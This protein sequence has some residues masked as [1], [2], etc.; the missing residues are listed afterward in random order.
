[1]RRRASLLPSLSFALIIA[2]CSS[3]TTASPSAPPAAP[4]AAPAASAPAASA[5]AS[6]ATTT[7]P[8]M[9]AKPEDC[10]PVD[11]STPVTISMW[12]NTEAPGQAVEEAMIAEYMAANPNVTIEY[13]GGM[14]LFDSFDRFQAA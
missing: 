7:G 13:T 9:A 10:P 1:M 2:A 14:D 12:S 3:G 11:T 6:G 5:P 8:L 4:S